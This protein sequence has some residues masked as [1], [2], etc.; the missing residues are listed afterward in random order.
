MAR[1]LN[2]NLVTLMYTTDLEYPY[3]GFKTIVCEEES[4]GGLD[5]T[6]NTTATK[7]GNFSTT[8]TPSGTITGSGVVN[9]DPEADEASFQE[10][11]ALVKN[12]T[13]VYVVYQ[14]AADSPDVTE[15]QGVFMAGVGYFNTARTTATQGTQV[16]FNWGF[17]FSDEVDVEY[18]G[19]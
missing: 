11:L 13:R 4:E 16:R 8:E 3:T 15:G 6:V 7:C 18:P 12:N 9:A 19:S 5:A 14:N 1:E 17:T 10:L 2:G